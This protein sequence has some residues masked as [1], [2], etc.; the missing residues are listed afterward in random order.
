MCRNR[1][2]IFLDRTIMCIKEIA[3]KWP[4]ELVMSSVVSQHETLLM[5]RNVV[6]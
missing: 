5:Y 2:N 6:S 1:K 3:Q 4:P